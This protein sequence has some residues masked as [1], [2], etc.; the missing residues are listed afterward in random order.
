MMLRAGSKLTL[1]KVSLVSGRILDVN[2]R[3][4]YF[5]WMQSNI[6]FAGFPI[7][8][9]SLPNAKRRG[10][11]M[12]PAP[13]SNP[14]ALGYVLSSLVTRNWQPGLRVRYWKAFESFV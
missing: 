10:A 6:V 2:F 12:D 4:N 3:V 5:A 13:G 14:S 11:L 9:G 1:G 8:I 7:L